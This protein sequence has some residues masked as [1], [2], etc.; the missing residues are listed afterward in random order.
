MSSKVSL[1]ISI[2]LH[3]GVAFAQGPAFERTPL[4]ILEKNRNP[5]NIMVIYTQL[6]S[7]CRVQK[8]RGGSEKV[9]FDFYWLMKRKD[10]KQVNPIIKKEIRS[11]LELLPSNDTHSF[12]VMM[13]D[14]K[15]LDTDIKD[16]K[17][18]VT[19]NKKKGNCV[20]ESILKLGESDQN[21]KV[22]LESIYAESKGF[23]IPTVISVTVNGIDAETGAKV[24]RKY[25]KK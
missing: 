19:A 13:N 15:E 9:V 6:D 18:I 5:E 20:T 12:S 23:L 1:L 17:L 25:M 14:L 7:E 24:T 16:F 21:K 11:R 2:I 8:K 10:F 4:F 22:K 3:A